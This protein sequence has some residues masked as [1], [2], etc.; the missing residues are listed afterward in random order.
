MIHISRRHPGA[1][2]ALEPTPE[3]DYLDRRAFLKT[4]GLAGAGLAIGGAAAGIAAAERL[5]SP[6]AAAGGAAPAGQ[7][8]TGSP[9]RALYPARRN[10]RF[11]LDRPLTDE[12]VAATHNNFYEFTEEKS[13]VWRQVDKFR[14]R[15]WRIEI[16]GLVSQP[17]EIDLDDL[18]RRLPSEERLYRHRCVEAW[19]MAVPWTGVP[20]REFVR[21]ADPLSSAKFVRTVSFLRPDEAPNQK[22]ATWYHWPYYEGLRMDEAMNELAML[23]FGIYGHDLPVQHGAPLRVVTPWKYG[24]KSAKSIVRFEFLERQPPTFWNDVAPGEYGFLSNVNPKV[25]H[26]R[27]SQASEKLIG[28][29][30]RRPTLPYNGYA[31]W[32]AGLYP[33]KTESYRS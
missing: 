16:A 12:R 17:R 22:R 19:A 13:E 28:T 31:E 4:L 30:E 23:V 21:W 24:Y 11:T 6:G 27:W 3:S 9:P 15:P 7:A 25:P 10:P 14:A 8:P 32:V 18:I 20:M 1:D 2:P 26:P 5:A 33:K 29:G